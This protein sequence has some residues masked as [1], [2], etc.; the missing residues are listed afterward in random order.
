M[1][2]VAALLALTTAKTADPIK[3]APSN[4]RRSSRWFIEIPSLPVGQVP[5]PIVKIRK[6]VKTLTGRSMAY[7]QFCHQVL[8][9]LAGEKSRGLTLSHTNLTAVK[10][11]WPGVRNRLQKATCEP[12][13]CLHANEMTCIVG[14]RVRVGLTALWPQTVKDRILLACPSSEHLALFPVSKKSACG[15]GSP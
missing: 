10:P 7:R 5:D 4:E 11:L 13:A 6:I 8:C 14:R 12:H 9:S 2:A 1:T 15:R 3:V